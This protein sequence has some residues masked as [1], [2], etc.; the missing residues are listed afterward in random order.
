MRILFLTNLLPY[1]LDNGGKIKTY[2]TLQSFYNAGFKVDLLCF[3]ENKES[4]ENN[5][6]SLLKLCCSVKEIYLKI[7]TAEHKAYMVRKAAISLFTKY[8]FGTYKFISK[9]M[10][11][12][13]KSYS[14]YQYDCIYI[15]HLQMYVYAGIIKKQWPNAKIILDEH[16]CE[17]QIMGRNAKNTKSIIKRAF[18]RIET[19]KLGDF[20]GRA[21]QNVDNT[22]VLSEE[23]KLAISENGKKTFQCTVI[24]IGMNAP[25]NIKKIEENNNT[26]QKILFLG[27][28]TW[29]PNNEGVI[30]FIDNVY[31]NLPSGRYKLY[32]VGKNPSE[33]IK[34]F[35]K[36][37][38][39]I[40]LTG[41]VD[42]VDPYYEMCDFMVVPLFVGSGQR[43]KI[44]ESFSR[45]MPVISTAIGAEGLN[46][47]D[48]RDLLIANTEDEFIKD[49]EL[50]RDIKLRQY[51]SNNE[52][53]LFEVDYSVKS[54]ER[55]IISAITQM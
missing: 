5:E 34:E 51:L 12:V 38:K 8:S 50:M 18:M 21:V 53:K 19:K 27:T 22:I 14:D 40:I 13:I 32:I 3:K 26:V 39:D 24:P 52:R 23:D 31:R 4:N 29:E 7:T 46:C 15:D 47:I 36:E 17:T 48:G 11:N 43:V 44:I 6:K 9:E 1:P 16:N 20:E 45:G 30:W 41:Y 54:V 33:K 35:C 25:S 55:K 42:S 37:F 49:I 28:M 2:T 10:L